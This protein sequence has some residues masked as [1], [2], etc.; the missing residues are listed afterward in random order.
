MKID[1]DKRS[2]F[3]PA[4]ISETSQ[5]SKI[6]YKDILITISSFAIGMISYRLLFKTKTSLAEHLFIFGGFVFGYIFGRLFKN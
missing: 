1:T 5:T 2:T 6:N 4:M 3:E